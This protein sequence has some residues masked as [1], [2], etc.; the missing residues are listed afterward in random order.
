MSEGHR[1]ERVS[2]DARLV[3]R[4]CALACRRGA[5]ACE[6]GAG[7]GRDGSAPA[8][9]SEHHSQPARGLALLSSGA[10]VV[11]S[12]WAA[13]PWACCR[14]AQA[15][16][17]RGA[18][19]RPAQCAP[20]PHNTHTNRSR[21]ARPARH[22]D[23]V[24]FEAREHGLP[25][26]GVPLARL[27]AGL[28]ALLQLAQLPVRLACRVQGRQ[29][30]ECGVGKER[31][32]H[33]SPY[34]WPVPAGGVSGVT[35]SARTA[36]EG[37]SCV[38]CSRLAAA[39]PQ[40]EERKAHVRWCTRRQGRTVDPRL[41]RVDPPRQR[42]HVT[43][44]GPT[45]AARQRPHP[46]AWRG[47]PAPRRRARRARPPPPPPRPPPPPPRAR[48]ASARGPPA[49]RPHTGGRTRLSAPRTVTRPHASASAFVA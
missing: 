3:S 2:R 41:H 8:N 29:G 24:D 49:P 39:A 37:T 32:K 5:R 38:R 4:T 21:P 48:R 14:G 20:S 18:R 11:G 1:E 45:L 44:L 7:C 19:A 12:D 47:S 28:H 34:D 9:K 22:T 6:G 16:T 10:G 42:R 17:L 46:A 26:L 31:T 27:E 30:E 13:P 36:C 25:V 35:Q 33:S 40:T 15:R 43:T 23:L